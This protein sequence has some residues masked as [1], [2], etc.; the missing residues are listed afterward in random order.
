MTGSISKQRVAQEVKDRALLLAT[1]FNDGQDAFDKAA[2]AI[3]LSTMGV[4]SPDNRVTQRAFG[5]VVDR[6]KAGYGDKAPQV[7]ISSQQATTRL[8]GP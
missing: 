6:L 7:R 5:A 4:T 8:S 1:G 3:R 2:A